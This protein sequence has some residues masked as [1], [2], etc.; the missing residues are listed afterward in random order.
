[1]TAIDPFTAWDTINLNNLPEHPPVQPT[2]G[3]V[4]GIGLLY[5]GKRHVFSG[6]QES[7]KTLIAYLLA[8][9]VVRDGGTI[10]LIDF[11]MGAYDARARLRDLGA[12][13]DDLNGIHYTEPDTPAT[14]D[15]M[16]ALLHLEPNL[17]IVDAA[18]GAYDLQGLDD[19]KRGDVEKIT[20]LYVRTFWRAGIATIFLDHVVKNHETRGSYAIGSERKV[21]GSD[22]HLGFTVITPIS[23]GH[24]GLYKIATHKDRGGYLKRGTLA[25]MELTS[26]PETHAI[27]YEFKQPQDT[28][29]DH[30]WLPTKV[31]QKISELLE[32]ET[33]PVSRNHICLH[34]GGKRDIAI[35]AID[36]LIRLKYATETAGPRNSKLIETSRSFTVLEWENQPNTPPVPTCSPPVPGTTDSDLFPAPLKGA[37]GNRSASNGT[38]PPVPDEQTAWSWEDELTPPDHLEH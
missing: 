36:A 10:I 8:I 12:T 19:N 20:R 16:A 7:A 1:M 38:A 24:S 3:R 27:T 34:I 4:G 29:H 31:M 21:G 28:D 30:P 15:R 11:E 35:K 9:Q 6:P 26:H 18:A 32:Q 37:G 2:L 13:T 22:V 25:E 17:V 5:P 23:R 14:P 33:E